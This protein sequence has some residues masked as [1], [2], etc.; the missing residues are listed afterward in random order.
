MC[1]LDCGLT[2]SQ[3]AKSAEVHY[4][5]VISRLPI[6]AVSIYDEFL[7]V[8]GDI[9]L[10]TIY[11]REPDIDVAFTAGLC[12]WDQTE[13][14]RLS[15]MNSASRLQGMVAETEANYHSNKK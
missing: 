1:E 7:E 14:Q 5:H 2:P 12:E 15:L 11:G 3:V 4:P 6:A 8:D 9:L 10:K 13:Q